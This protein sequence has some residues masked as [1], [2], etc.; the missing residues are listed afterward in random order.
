MTTTMSTVL[1]NPTVT[2]AAADSKD[3]ATSGFALVN[4]K[5]LDVSKITFGKPELNKKNAPVI[6]VLY[7]GKRWKLQFPKLRI[8]FGANLS[9]NENSCVCN[10]A[11]E[12]PH[13]A[14]ISEKLDE[15]DNF[16][17][18]SATERSKEWFKKVRTLDGIT[19]TYKS[20]S[21]GS[22][23]LDKSG[24]AYS[25]TIH[26]KIYQMFPKEG[27]PWQSG[28]IKTEV[29]ND[30]G[31]KLVTKTPDQLF[32][33]VTK[34]CYGKFAVDVSNIWIMNESSFGLKFTLSLLM[35]YPSAEPVGMYLNPDSDDEAPSSSS[36]SSSTPLS[37]SAPSAVQ[38]S[39]ISND[40]FNNM[41]SIS[42]ADDSADPPSTPP[43][44]KRPPKTTK[45]KK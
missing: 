41:T 28:E 22:G 16:V 37:L 40:I 36:S 7:E 35:L 2:R 42:P 19:D 44:S 27:E 6:K 11:I 30:R 24:N 26:T 1:A 25:K 33:T 21:R 45:G 17:L 38:T 34:N 31:I 13:A 20:I 29:Y 23:K 10:F 5:D 18:K 15:L 8:P 4:I 39:E 12:G 14:M 3:S 9:L 32:S 43:S